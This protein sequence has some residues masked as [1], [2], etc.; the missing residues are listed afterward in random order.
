MNTIDIYCVNTGAKKEYPLGITLMEIKDDFQVDL[1]NPILGAMVNN[2]VKDLSYVFVKNKRVEFI[3]YSHPDGL[4][5]YVRSLFFILFASVREIFPE[6]KLKMMHGISRG[7]YCELAGLERPITESDIFEIKNEM[8]Q[9]VQKDIPFEK[10]GLPNEEAVGR[11]LYFRISILW[12]IR[13]TIFTEIRCHLPDIYKCSTLFNTTMAC[14]FGFQI[15]Q[16]S[17]R[18]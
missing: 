7:Y 5:L 1:K 11:E 17:T 2:K 16:N 6:V 10:I 18:F 3:D 12:A 15:L 9:L 8:R 14:Y 4:R 13:P